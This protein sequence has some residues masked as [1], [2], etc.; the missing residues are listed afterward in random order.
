MNFYTI[1]TTVVGI[2]PSLVTAISTL[3]TA[4]P[5]DDAT[6]HKL[7]TLKTIIQASHDAADKVTVPFEQ[8][9]T[10][11]VPIIS[12]VTALHQVVSSGSTKST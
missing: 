10:T 1:F 5:Q 11:L 8:L 7:E 2:L 4:F 12:I 6:A 3:E 9:W